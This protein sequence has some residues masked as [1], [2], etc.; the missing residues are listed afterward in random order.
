VLLWTLFKPTLP[1]RQGKPHHL[2]SIYVPAFFVPVNRPQILVLPVGVCG[3]SK[4]DK[5]NQDKTP[6]VLEIAG[7]VEKMKQRWGLQF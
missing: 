7:V 6:S 3:L 4:G 2:A 5:S 1:V